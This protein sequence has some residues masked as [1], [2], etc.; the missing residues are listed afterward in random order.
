MKIGIIGVGAIGKAFAKHVAKAGY[1]VVVS[2]SRGP[3]SLAVIV[4]EIGSNIKAGTV[5]DAGEADVVFVSVPWPGL[6]DI[7]KGISWENKTL[8]DPTNPFLPGFKLADLGGKSS[9]E[10]V[11][12]MV[13]KA[14]YVKAFNTLQAAILD[15]DP[16]EAGGKRVIFYAG[17][18]AAK[19]NLQEILDR[20]GFAGIDVGDAAGGGRLLD[21]ATG[22]LANLNVLKLS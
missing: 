11:K 19:T 12:R 9:A 1:D 10:V 18:D 15:S 17:D 8:I 7:L 21:M 3:E 6:E 20:I 16:H 5:E 22:S 2:N 13:P 14:N 4:Q